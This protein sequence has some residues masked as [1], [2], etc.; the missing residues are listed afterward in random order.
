MGGERGEADT[1][2]TGIA[3]TIAELCSKPSSRMS[4]LNPQQCCSCHSRFT[5]K[6]TEA[7]ESSRDPSKPPQLASGRDRREFLSV[8]LQSP[9]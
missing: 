3:S 1:G 7:T 4:S 2:L 8:G 6:T 9:L 5:E